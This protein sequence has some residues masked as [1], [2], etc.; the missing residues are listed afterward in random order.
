[1]TKV[2]S[3]Q[4]KGDEHT[5]DPIL[6]TALTRP[7]SSSQSGNGGKAGPTSKKAKKLDN[8]HVDEEE[9]MGISI[10]EDVEVDQGLVT[11]LAPPTNLAENL[12]ED[13]GQTVQEGGIDE[14]SEAESQTLGDE[15]TYSLP[16]ERQK[17]PK[18][19]YANLFFKN[20]MPSEDSKLN[21]VKLEEGPKI[22][23]QEEDI[24]GL[25][26]PW[27]Q[28]LV[29][30]FGGK[31]PGKQALNQIVKSWK[32]HVTVQHHGSGWIIFQFSTMEDLTHVL[33]NGPYI[34]YGRPLLLKTM[35]RYFAFENESISTFPVWVQLKHFPLDIWG[36]R[37]FEKICSK[38]G[39]P[40]H[41]D[42]LTTKKERMNFARCLVEIDL[43]KDLTH[44]ATLQL[45]G[46]VDHEQP[47]FYENLP[48]FCPQ[49]RMMGHTKG[50]CKRPKSL[51]K[52]DKT[53]ESARINS[54]KRKEKEAAGPEEGGSQNANS[55]EGTSKGAE[56]VVKKTK[57]GRTQMN[58]LE[59]SA[60][61]GS[62]VMEKTSE[63]E[64]TNKFS[65]LEVISENGETEETQA[66]T[67]P[68]PEVEGQVELDA[69][70]RTVPEVE[71]CAELETEVA[72]LIQI[73]G[74]STV[75]ATKKSAG[76]SK[77]QPPKKRVGEA[78]YVQQASQI[79]SAEL[80]NNLKKAATD[81]KEIPT[82]KKAADPK[83]IPTQIAKRQTM[84]KPI[85]RPPDKAAN[86]TSNPLSS[87][88][89]E[90]R[91]KRGKKN[92]EKEGNSV[93]FAEFCAEMGGDSPN[94]IK[95]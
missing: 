19:S 14:T 33:E 72:E 91:K 81:P 75:Q 62:I 66:N 36:P 56:W 71:D 47:I 32:V 5:V 89:E 11:D 46:G 7:A 58:R 88:G 55:G 17:E 80:R 61:A 41:M 1:M 78:V 21:F 42:Q 40:V 51:P 68:D 31:F 74:P 26:I 90:G 69:E 22:I 9:E 8:P 52:G 37:V 29:G 27:E 48:R 44:S 59:S 77:E 16:E 6:V 73:E 4:R 57:A 15:D 28:S 79:A 2:K 12:T 65:L 10:A 23:I 25:N 13:L 76:T 95:Q 39:K 67:Q 84:G 70:D 50:S 45:P 85:I 53:V 64:T 60:K 38:I 30:Y 63:T 86:S 87:M 34:I 54:G 35:P 93:V 92:Q 20:R 24:Q 43:A 3:K 18:K 94:P 49:C 82:Q 83:E